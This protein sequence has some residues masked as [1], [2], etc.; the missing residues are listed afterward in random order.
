M[1]ICTRVAKSKK[2]RIFL[3]KNKKEQKK[4]REQL[5]EQYIDNYYMFLHACCFQNQ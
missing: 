1:E 3:Q 2:Y 5:P 4:R